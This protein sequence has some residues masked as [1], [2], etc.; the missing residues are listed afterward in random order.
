MNPFGRCVYLYWTVRDESTEY[1]YSLS[2]SRCRELRSL[3]LL[4]LLLSNRFSLYLIPLR[5]P[6]IAVYYSYSCLHIFLLRL[7]LL[8]SL[9]L[10]SSCFHF[11][12]LFIFLLFTLDFLYV[13]F[14]NPLKNL[15]PIS[16]TVTWLWPSS[17]P[18]TPGRPSPVLT[19]P[20]TRPRSPWP[21]VTTSSTPLC[22]TCLW[23]GL[24]PRKMAGW[25]I[26]LPEPLG[27][28]PTTWPGLCATSPTRRPQ[29][30]AAS[31]SVP[32][33]NRHKHRGLTGIRVLLW[34]LWCCFSQ[35]GV[36]FGQWFLNILCATFGS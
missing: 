26:T 20:S 22:P 3:F 6:F 13:L 18:S 5:F 10:L 28:R 27:C 12:H 2:G 32:P 17:V 16:S 29:Q 7:L 24:C 11:C 25:P 33:K 9:L 34:F 21:C 15:V 30:R 8:F 31:R 4:L 35:S 1:S 14:F 23:R 19:S 36:W